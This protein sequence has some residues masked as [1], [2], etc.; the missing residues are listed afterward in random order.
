MKRFNKI[1]GIVLSIHIVGS[2]LLLGG[3]ISKG[4]EQTDNGNKITVCLNVNQEEGQELKSIIDKYADEN[5]VEVNTIISDNA[6]GAIDEYLGAAQAKNAPDIEFGLSHEYMEKLIKL[7]LAEEADS[8]IVN[9]DD[10]ISKDLVDSV[11]IDGKIYGYPISQECPALYYNKEKVK[12]LPSSMEDIVKKCDENKFQYDINN[13]YLSYGFLSAD[14]GYAFKNNDGSFDRN[15][16]GLDNDG[17]VKGYDFIQS[18]CQKYDMI[19]PEINDNNAELGFYDGENAYYL[20]EAKKLP[21][22][23]ENKD[24]KFGVMSI[25]SLNGNTVKPLKGV[26][27]ALVSPRSKKKEEAYKLLKYLIENSKEALMSKGCRLPVFKDAL[28]TEAFKNDEYLN[29]FFEQS[30]N[31]EIMPNII[32][33]ET[34]W[35][36]AASN[37]NLL[38]TGQVSPEECGKGMIKGV[39]ENIDMLG[40]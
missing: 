23:K 19:P 16:M 36:P 34:I 30:K 13:F 35:Q 15:D 31:S 9:F 1:I 8:S 24:L 10:Y 22:M 32:V 21:M 40:Q 25:P 29:G 4:E 11:T 33:T 3:C 20:G 14:G 6:A 18:L 37:L 39:K 17:A 28:N 38:V 7:N 27:I 12:N 2:M 26:K 5:S